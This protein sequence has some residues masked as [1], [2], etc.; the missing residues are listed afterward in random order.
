MFSVFAFPRYSHVRF[1]R[2]AEVLCGEPLLPADFE[3]I[4]GRHCA[5]ARDILQH[6]SVPALVA[7]DK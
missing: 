1:V 5:Q 3:G 2:T 6:K 7:V 4:V